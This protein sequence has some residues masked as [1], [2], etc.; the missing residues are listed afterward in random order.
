MAR[1]R[2][3]PLSIDLVDAQPYS[4]TRSSYYD[5]TSYEYSLDMAID[6]LVRIYENQDMNALE[7][8]VQQGTDVNIQS[9]TGDNYMLS[10]DDF[11]DL[12][13]DNMSTTR[14]QQFA[15]VQVQKFRAGARVRAIHT[16]TD[17]NGNTAQLQHVYTLEQDEH[18]YYIAALRVTRGSTSF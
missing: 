5:P 4:W 15:I 17:P 11:H 12:M 18:G 3:G 2:V 9:E 8:L 7:S 14:T 10:S 6:R 1:I 16:F 13:L